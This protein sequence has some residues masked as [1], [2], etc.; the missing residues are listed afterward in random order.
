LIL[1]NKNSLTVQLDITTPRLLF[2]EDVEDDNSSIL[3]V[4]LGQL[5]VE[6]KRST[7]TSE[8]TQISFLDFYDEYEVK[9]CSIFDKGN[10]LFT[11]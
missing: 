4:D 6:T 5:L 9:L 2:P 8:A 10:S 1:A 3:V 7:A 11:L